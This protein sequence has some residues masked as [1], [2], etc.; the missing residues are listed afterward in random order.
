MKR[1]QGGKEVHM[2]HLCSSSCRISTLHVY[3]FGSAMTFFGRV[4]SSP[5]L[6]AY[7]RSYIL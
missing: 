4:V 2:F 5:L 7:P 3:V 6:G 1:N